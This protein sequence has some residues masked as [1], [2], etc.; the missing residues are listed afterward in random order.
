M[1]YYIDMNSLFAIPPPIPEIEQL[2][3]QAKI[4]DMGQN[5]NTPAKQKLDVLEERLQAIEMLKGLTFMKI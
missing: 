1:Q 5:E 2:E 4:Q 3:A